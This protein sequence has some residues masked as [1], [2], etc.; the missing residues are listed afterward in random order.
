MYLIDEERD[1][2]V[3]GNHQAMQT[4]HESDEQNAQARRSRGKNARLNLRRYIKTSLDNIQPSREGA[5]HNCPVK[6]EGEGALNYKIISN[7]MMTKAKVV[8][9]DQDSALAYMKEIGKLNPKI[10]PKME[11]P[12]NKLCLQVFQNVSTVSAVR[13]AVAYMYKRARI[14]QPEAMKNEM[15]LFVNGMKR[16][17]KGAKTHIG[18]KITEGKEPLSVEAFEFLAK[19]LFYSGENICAPLFCARLGSDEAGRKCGRCE[20]KSHL[21]S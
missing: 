18:L 14:D 13:S 21:V 3:D 20:N 2:L 6:I 11:A 17:E 9:V 12:N 4:L 15:S 10:S 19:K 8:T 7:Y 5:H 16:C 1:Y